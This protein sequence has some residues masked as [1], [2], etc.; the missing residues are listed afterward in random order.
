MVLMASAAATA[1]SVRVK[2]DCDDIELSFW[3]SAWFL[4]GR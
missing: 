1:M 2:G 3:W 4:A